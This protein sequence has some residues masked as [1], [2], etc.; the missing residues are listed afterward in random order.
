MKKPA[1]EMKI[2]SSEESNNYLREQNP[3]MLA[4]NSDITFSF[5]FFTHP[6]YLLQLQKGKSEQEEKII[7]FFY[8]IML[9]N[10]KKDF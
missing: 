6:Y 9:R 5:F 2:L 1:K 3:E 10:K 4:W 8:G 7:I